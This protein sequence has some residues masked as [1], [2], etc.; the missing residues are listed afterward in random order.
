ML[1]YLYGLPGTGKNFIGEIFKSRFNF[2][3]Q[4]ADEYLPIKMKNKLKNGKHFT[5]EDV[6]E[7]HHIIANKI[8]ELRE[9]HKKLVISQASLF[10]EHRQIIKNKNPL[11][12]FIHINSDRN[13]II[14]RLNNRK[15]YVT[16]K[17]MLDIEKYLEIDEED[18][19]INNKSND[20]IQSIIVQILKIIKK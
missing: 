5:R 1:I 2:Y 18:D 8:F 9:K 4:D 19:I 7:Y 11:V 15:G 20:T 10:I 16:E 12:K 17:Y 14:S 6:Y 13:T 3:F